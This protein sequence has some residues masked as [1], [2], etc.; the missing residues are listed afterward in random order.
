MLA[1]LVAL[2][3]AIG[4]FSAKIGI[5]YFK[6]ILWMIF[7]HFM[8]FFWMSIYIFAIEK[9]RSIV[10]EWKTNKTHIGL[11]VVIALSAFILGAIALNIS[12]LSYITFASRLSIFFSVLLGI[13][14]LREKYGYIKLLASLFIFF[15]VILISLG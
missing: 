10:L 4:G 8:L 9:G 3:T 13:F 12:K 5:H 2:V 15:G 1:L 7:V 11:T 6:P 14:V